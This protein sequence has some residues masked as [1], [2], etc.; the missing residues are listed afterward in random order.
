MANRDE[1]TTCKFDTSLTTTSSWEQLCYKVM[2]D[3]VVSPTKVNT[4]WWT[5]TAEKI[6]R[7]LTS[8]VTSLIQEDPA[9]SLSSSRQYHERHNYIREFKKEANQYKEQL[10]I[11]ISPSATGSACT[12]TTNS[13][14]P[15]P[16]QDQGTKTTTTTLASSKAMDHHDGTNSE[17]CMTTF[18]N[19]DSSSDH[20]HQRAAGPHS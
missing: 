6:T 14:H 5:T 13:S 17:S 3:S 19:Q 9:E 8:K 2:H 16:S 12:S 10:Q 18:Q 7:P 20:E 11:M 1:V 15:H 4:R